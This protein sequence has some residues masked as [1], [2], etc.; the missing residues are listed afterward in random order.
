ME[1]LE[2]TPP[3]LGWEEGKELN[4][5]VDMQD[6]QLTVLY[7]HNETTLSR[8]HNNFTMYS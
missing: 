8:C 3:L 6:Y 4:T 2:K 5:V 7:K 1:Q